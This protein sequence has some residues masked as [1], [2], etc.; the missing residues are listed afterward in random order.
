MTIQTKQTY[1]SLP[2]KGNCP[3]DH[4]AKFLQD[5]LHR[6]VSCWDDRTEVNNTK[7][8]AGSS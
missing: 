8:E 2:H 5:S 3:F 7:L 6:P 4:Q 1:Q